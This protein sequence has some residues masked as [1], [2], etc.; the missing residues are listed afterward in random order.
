MKRSQL[1]A[2]TKPV[3]QLRKSLIALKA[4]PTRTS[5]A[6]DFHKFWT[7]L[8]SEPPIES[9]LDKL[10]NVFRG[11]FLHIHVCLEVVALA[12][13]VYPHS[14]CVQSERSF[15]HCLGE[16]DQREASKETTSTNLMYFDRRF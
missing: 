13:G 9:G 15:Q 2:C 5:S 1:K 12:G 7:R 6:V 10:H 8:Q 3:D 14:Y 16:V 4:D 11:G